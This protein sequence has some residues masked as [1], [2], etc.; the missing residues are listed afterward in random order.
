[1]KRLLVFLFF[2]AMMVAPPT[3]ADII[4]NGNVISTTAEV[5]PATGQDTR[6]I[7]VD[8]RVDGDG[9]VRVIDGDEAEGGKK[10]VIVDRKGAFLGIYFDEIDRKMRRERD[11]PKKTGVLVTGLVEDGPAGEAGIEEGDIIYSFDGEAVE[12]GGHLVEMIADREPG[13]EVKI[14]LYRDGKKKEIDLELGRHERMMHSWSSEDV[15]KKYAELAPRFER[16]GE[17]YRVMMRGGG[18]R[19]GVRLYPVKDPLADYFDVDTGALV[20]EVL[21]D[22]PAE[23]AGIE[24]GDVIVR[25]GDEAIESP[26]DVVEYL[27]ELD[28]GDEVELMIVRKG[29]KKTV[30]VELDDDTP[31]DWHVYGFGGDAGGERFMWRVPRVEKVE[32]PHIRIERKELEKELE[33]LKEEMK[34]LQERLEK[35]ER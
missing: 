26:D 2:A 32:I 33:K 31:A 6:E 15:E 14:V 23:E 17:R 22:G 5:Q 18:P 9:D 7:R 24:P 35:L 4:L 20:L 25:A 27:S 12:D 10:I 19:I 16:L 30:A 29:K 28:E 11:Y 8:V 3:F 21:E 1:M 34:R 13:D